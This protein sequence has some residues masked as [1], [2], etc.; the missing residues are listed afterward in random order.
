MQTFNTY[1]IE[2]YIFEITTDVQNNDIP[3]IKLLQYYYE[4]QHKRS[5][6]LHSND[7]HN[8]INRIM[9]T[10][11]QKL[12]QN[13]IEIFKK[14]MTIHFSDHDFEY[15]LNNINSKE[16]FHYISNNLSTNDSDVNQKSYIKIVKN[17]KKAYNL[18]MNVKTIGE[19]IAA[20]SVAK[21]VLHHSGKNYSIIKDYGINLKDWETFDSLSD[22][23]SSILKQYQK[24]IE[25]ES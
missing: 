9:H 6:V 19:E 11:Y 10:I 5:F 14:W 24:E 23:P 21:N 1:V 12:C 22:I 2:S 17:I 25:E 8:K 18:L 13:I 16:M 7:L 3:F 20:I 15:V 4:L